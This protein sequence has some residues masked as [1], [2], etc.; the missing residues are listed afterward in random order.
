MTGKIVLLRAAVLV[1][2]LTL[3]PM[4]EAMAWGAAG[5]AIIAEI[6]QRRLDPVALRKV[7]DLLGG[8]VS[9]AAIANLADTIAATRPETRNWHFVNIPVGATGY[10]P[11]RDCAATPH[12]DCIV[13]A[14]ARFRAVLADAGK[15]KAERAEA[16]VFLVHLVGDI[17]QPLH[18][19]ERNHDAGASTL[20][21]TFFGA[22]MSLH[23]VWDVGLIE[24]HTYDWGDYADH[25]QRD[26]LAGRDVAQLARGEP[27]D[28]AW[29]AHQA[30]IDVAYALP[31]DLNLGDSYFQH[32][33]ITV[34]R[35][36]AL[37]GVRLARLLNEA[38]K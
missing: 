32:S 10:D 21:V 36:L 14:I 2:A 24:K 30:A 38:L 31:E 22:P 12:G 13:K 11:D 37:A 29:E 35:Q 25:L 34:D 4:R 3:V 15:P 33:S 6:A 19:A 28:W 26:W 23:L 5:H 9:L 27:A 8:E 17:H 18:C 7:K 20:K 1:F 16:L